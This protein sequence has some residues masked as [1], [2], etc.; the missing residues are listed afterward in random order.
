MDAKT[1]AK[2]RKAL[3]ERRVEIEQ[4][5]SFMAGEIKAIGDEQGDEAGGLGNHMAEDGSSLN[6]AERLTTITDD[7]EGMLGQI[8]SALRR[9]DE[10]TYG[11]CER[12]GKPIPE[13]RLEA[14][15]HVLFCIECQAMYE[16]ELAIRAGR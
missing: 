12:C 13:A 14:F 16:R 1:L 11:M 3:E 6:E 15:P 8:A 10:G 5:V 4:D 2:L 7:M 9:M